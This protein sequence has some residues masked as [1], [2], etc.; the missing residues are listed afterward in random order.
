MAV[1]FSG[2]AASVGP[3]IP[4]ASLVGSFGGFEELCTLAPGLDGVVGVADDLRAA[5]VNNLGVRLMGA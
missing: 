4:S 2:F 5:L 3:I 1:A